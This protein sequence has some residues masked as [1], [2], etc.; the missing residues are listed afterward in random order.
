MHQRFPEDFRDP[1]ANG[2]E[3]TIFVPERQIR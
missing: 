1:P 2:Q 3:R